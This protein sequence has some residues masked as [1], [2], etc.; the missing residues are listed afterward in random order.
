MI[1][2][3]CGRELPDTARV[4][5]S[6]NA[7][8]RVARRR[9]AEADV[10]DAQQ[11]V[12]VS[13]RV[14]P[15]QEEAMHERERT[16]EQNAGT[17]STPNRNRR[18][19]PHR[20]APSA[21]HVPAGLTK[22]AAR[23]RVQV[24]HVRHAQEVLRR[25]APEHRPQPGGRRGEEVA[26]DRFHSFS[27]RSKRKFGGLEAWRFGSSP[28]GGE[29]TTDNRQPTMARRG[30]SAHLGEGGLGV[31]AVAPRAEDEQCREGEEDGGD[32]EDEEEGLFH[33]GTFR[34]VW[35]FGC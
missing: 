27:L 19:E 12:R 15:Q 5:P 28:R 13:R 16:G 25:Q 14:M 9:R 3:N 6:C 1:C 35:K 26:L 20:T 33:D 2:P 29:P 4:C 18:E 34:E 21:G 24:R 8:Q 22:Q 23:S 10:P 32:E 17:V 11:R 31:A 30:A 7:V